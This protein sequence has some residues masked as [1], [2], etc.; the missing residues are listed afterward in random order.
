MPERLLFSSTG[1]SHKSDAPSLLR[2]L[3]SQRLVFSS[4]GSDAQSGGRIAGEDLADA[5]VAGE[6]LG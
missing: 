3:F 4:Q 6:H 5:D 2:S 1:N